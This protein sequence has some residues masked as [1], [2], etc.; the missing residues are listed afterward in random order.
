[1][2]ADDDSDC[3]EHVWVLSEVVCTFRGTEEVHTCRRCGALRYREG[4]GRKNTRL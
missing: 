1:M 2:S 4:S 3:I